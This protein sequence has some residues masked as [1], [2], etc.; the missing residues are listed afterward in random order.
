MDKRLIDKILSEVSLD[1]RIS[2]G[3]FRIEEDDHM[4]ALREY[5]T[6]KG[7]SETEAISFSNRVLEGK[8]PER[9]AYNADGILV[10]FPTKEY[11]DD[12]IKAGTHFE[13]DPTK[14]KSNLFTSNQPSSTP[15]SSNQKKEPES[16]KKPAEDQPKTSLPVSQASPPSSQETPSEPIQAQT[17]AAPQQTPQSAA[18][19]EEPPEVKEPTDLPPLPAKSSQEKNANKQMIKTMLRGDDYMLD[20]MV[21]WFIHNAPEYLRE[22]IEEHKKQYER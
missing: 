7:I 19:A 22:H 20:E 2:D 11:K 18:P 10:T 6:K 21:E 4:E 15:P 16:A 17:T 5:L 13:K 1:D 8:Y 3:V 9:Q 14:G 12:A